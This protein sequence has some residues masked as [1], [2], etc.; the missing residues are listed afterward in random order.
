[1]NKITTNYGNRV[2][3][4]GMV[5]MK[6]TAMETIEERRVATP[7]LLATM[8]MRLIAHIERLENR[9]LDDIVAKRKSIKA[10]RS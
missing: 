10:S 2:S 9:T 1:V 5:A 4:L 8:I 3:G 6:T 7:H